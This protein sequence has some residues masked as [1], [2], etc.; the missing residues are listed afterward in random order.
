MWKVY[1]D[2]EMVRR[3]TSIYS[4][5]CPAEHVEQRENKI[6][7]SSLNRGVYIY[8]VCKIDGTIYNG[9]LIIE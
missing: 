3:T 4:S 8:K 9:K 1:N 5:T 2:I 7:V 6:A